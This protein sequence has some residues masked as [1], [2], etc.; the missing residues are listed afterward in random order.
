MV[1]AGVISHP[2]MWRFSGY[3]EIQEPRR[4]NVLIDYR[5]L[6][7]LIGAGTYDELRS[8]HKGWVE[9]YLGGGAKTRQEEWTCGIAASP[10]K[11]GI[12]I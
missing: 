1:R 9:E 4:K 12:F 8:S 7:S 3:N 11:S 10:V 2:S 6:Q 5:R